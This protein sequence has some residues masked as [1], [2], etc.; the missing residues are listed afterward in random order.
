[1]NDE[2]HVSGPAIVARLL[3]GDDLVEAHRRKAEGGRGVHCH[4]YI[5][6][7]ARAGRLKKDS[8]KTGVGHWDDW[9][10]VL[11]QSLSQMQTLLQKKTLTQS[12]RG[13]RRRCIAGLVL[14]C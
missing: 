14:K 9:L 1:M 11:E 7:V 10:V 5:G 3:V 12:E 13:R 2:F 6:A 8:R 4:Q